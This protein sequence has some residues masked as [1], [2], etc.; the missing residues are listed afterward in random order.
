MVGATTP[1]IRQTAG[2]QQ[3]EDWMEKRDQAPAIVK[4]S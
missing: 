1:S 4:G 2:A 3:G